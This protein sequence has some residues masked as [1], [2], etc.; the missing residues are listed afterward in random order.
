MSLR[1]IAEREGARKIAKL[2]QLTMHAPIP[3]RIT[4]Y[5]ADENLVAV[6]LVSGGS[7]EFGGT[8]IANTLF[9]LDYPPNESWM[10]GIEPGKTIGMLHLAGWQMKKGYVTIAHISGS[11]GICSYAPIRYGWA[12]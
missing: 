4:E 10:K 3:V 2:T 5:L 8:T 6:Q 1:K 11:S 12:V 7:F 9:P